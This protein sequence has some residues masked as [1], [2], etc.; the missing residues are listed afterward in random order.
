MPGVDGRFGAVE[1]IGLLGREFGTEDF[2]R[3][4]EELFRGEKDVSDDYS[5]RESVGVEHTFT[6][7]LLP[8][9]TSNRHSEPLWSSWTVGAAT[10]TGAVSWRPGKD[11]IAHCWMFANFLRRWLA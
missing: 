2:G 8:N 3:P 6:S 5:S 9:A 7:T 1:G 11:M 10:S 4:G